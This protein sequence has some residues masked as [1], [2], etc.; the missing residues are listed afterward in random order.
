MIRQI[1]DVFVYYDVATQ[2][3]YSMFIIIIDHII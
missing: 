1:E 2:M 3:T